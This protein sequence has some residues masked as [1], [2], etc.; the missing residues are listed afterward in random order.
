MAWAWGGPLAAAPQPAAPQ[1]A[2]PIP[3][4]IDTDIGDDIDDAFALAVALG[5]RGS[6]SSASPLRGGDTR[7]RTLLVRRLLAA[8][9]REDVV[10]AQGPATPNRVR[11]TQKQWALGATDTTPAP[12]AIEFIRAQVRKRPGAITLLALAP[13]SNVGR[14]RR[15]TLRS[16]TG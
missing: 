14:W 2:A 15:P 10:V 9:R 7:T 1:P 13:L 12:D 6:R 3:V 4:I 16:C 5:I 8:M 11:F